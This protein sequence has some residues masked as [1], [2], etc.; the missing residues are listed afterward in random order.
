MRK[1]MMLAAGAVG[2]VLGTR[3]GRDRYEE[4]KNMATKVKDDPRVQDRA[5]QAADI[6]R[7]K[8]PVVKDK[9]TDAASSA[10][11]KVKPSG[12]SSDLEDQLNP[13]STAL[14]DDPYPKGDLP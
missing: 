7:E 9:V 2:Y 11:H 1:L 6:A 4:I 13:D 14:Q 10:A 3:A 8:A 12:S 5:Q